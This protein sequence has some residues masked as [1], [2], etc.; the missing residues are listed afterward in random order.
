ME[1]DV[2]GTGKEL[3]HVVNHLA[4]NLTSEVRSIAMV[5]KAVAM[6]DLSEEIA[7][8]ARGEIL[9]FK[10]TVNEIV[11]RS[12]TMA[13]EVTRVTLEVGLHGR[14]GGQ[15]SITSLIHIWTTET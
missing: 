8:D 3:T 1:F 4:A 15:V 6:G 5:T 14:L 9:D 11:I 10:N 12:R 2:R 7:V 13:S